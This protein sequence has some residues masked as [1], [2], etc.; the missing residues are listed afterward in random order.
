MESLSKGGP[1]GFPLSRT[2]DLKDILEARF[3][4]LEVDVDEL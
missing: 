2:A 4:R 1:R 3:L